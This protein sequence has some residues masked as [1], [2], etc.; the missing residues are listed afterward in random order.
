[1]NSPE[2]G[3]FYFEPN[4][5]LSTFSGRQSAVHQSINFIIELMLHQH[6]NDKIM[7]LAKQIDCDRKMRKRFYLYCPSKANNVA[8]KWHRSLEPSL[9]LLSLNRRRHVRWMWL[10]M[11]R[12]HCIKTFVCSS[13]STMHSEPKSEHDARI[14]FAALISFDWLDKKFFAASKKLN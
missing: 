3:W 9:F 11:Y 5:I 2:R 6:D 8:S 12:L 13:S 10:V 1:M 7:R 4:F 14:N